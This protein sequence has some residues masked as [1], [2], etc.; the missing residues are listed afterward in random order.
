MRPFLNYLLSLISPLIFLISTVLI[1]VVPKNYYSDLEYYQNE[2]IKL[3]DNNSTIFFGDSSCGNGVDAKLFGENTYNLS[4]TGRYITCGSLVQL[5]KLIDRKKTPKEIIL[6]YTIDGYNR[7]LIPGYK[8]DNKSF[9]DDFYIKIRSFKNL[10]KRVVFKIKEPRLVID[11][12]NDYIKQKESL[13]D[14]NPVEIDINLSS[15]NK[16]C[17][18]DISNLCKK[19]NID[20]TFM[21]GPNI[22]LIDKSSLFKFKKFFETSQIKLN[23]EYYRIPNTEIGNSNDH[24]SPVFKSNSTQFYKVLIK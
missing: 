14:Y 22:N 7:S 10:V 16:K 8:L 2:K 18:I 24:I 15:D 4:L 1:F 9:K 20:Y 17:I 13:V 23:T 5:N 21:I 12:E 11:F 6:M 19:Y 3:I